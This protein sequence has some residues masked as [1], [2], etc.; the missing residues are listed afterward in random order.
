MR[1]HA[2]AA[3]NNGALRASERAQVLAFSFAG[4]LTRRAAAGDDDGG[5]TKR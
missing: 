2:L 4:G 1:R 3:R 5:S